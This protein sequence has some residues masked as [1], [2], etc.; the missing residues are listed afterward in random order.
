MNLTTTIKLFL[1]LCCQPESKGYMYE[2]KDISNSYEKI[3]TGGTVYTESH[4]NEGD[5]IRLIT[6]DW[7]STSKPPAPNESKD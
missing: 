5:T 3:V 1:V 6:L 4:Y 2:V 7:A